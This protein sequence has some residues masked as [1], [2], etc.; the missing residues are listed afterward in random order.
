MGFLESAG[1]VYLY[2]KIAGMYI[3]SIVFLIIGFVLINI[4]KKDKHSKKTVMT[5]S[6]VSC[7]PR[8]CNAIGN[9]SVNG[10]SYDIPVQYQVTDNSKHNVVYY[11]PKNPSDG[12]TSKIPSWIGFIFM[13]IGSLV[14]LI[15]FGFTIFASST[16][17]STRGV[18]GGFLFGMNAVSSF[19]RN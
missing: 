19:T 17:S 3:V 12:S 9:Y 4:S 18:A 15:A 6:N 8:N 14:L 10:S 11:D 7:D 1:N 2:Y 16:N 13:G 5:L